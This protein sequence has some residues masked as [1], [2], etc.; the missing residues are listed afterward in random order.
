[1]YHIRFF[2]FFAHIVERNG[3]YVEREDMSAPAWWVFRIYPET[4]AALQA[5]FIE[6]FKAWEA[7]E[8][9][10][11][12]VRK[13]PKGYR[14]LK[15]RMDKNVREIDK[16]YAEVNKTVEELNEDFRKACRE[17][18]DIACAFRKLNESIGGVNEDLE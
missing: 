7:L 9:T 12:I 11:A 1:M 13:T 16:L 15:K 17:E 4:I 8:K 6:S 3:V 5:S 14:A 10:R 18:L 2:S